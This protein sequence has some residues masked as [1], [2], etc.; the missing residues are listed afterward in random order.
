MSRVYRIY[1]KRLI[2]N[3]LAFTECYE[4]V[5]RFTISSAELKVLREQIKEESDYI[6]L[7]EKDYVKMV[8]SHRDMLQS[9]IYDIDLPDNYKEFA[10]IGEYHPDDID[11]KLADIKECNKQLEKYDK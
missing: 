6:L 8:K 9:Q 2:P 11:Q 3:D 4:L 5:N 7:A 10:S 1:K